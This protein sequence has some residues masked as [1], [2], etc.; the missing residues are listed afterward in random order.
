MPTDVVLLGVQA[1]EARRPREGDAAH[2]GR[3]DAVVVHEAPYRVAGDEGVAWK[4]RDIDVPDDVA[5]VRHDTADVGP[6]TGHPRVVDHLA[7][8]GMRVEVFLAVDVACLVTGSGVPGV[9]RQTPVDVHRRGVGR[10][11]CHPRNTR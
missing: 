2:R 9:V 5:V 7:G 1:G 8:Q 6:A 4:V 10:P 3:A 11:P